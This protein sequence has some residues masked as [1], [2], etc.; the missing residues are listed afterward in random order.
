MMETS[1]QVARQLDEDWLNHLLAQLAEF[2]KL[3]DGG[4]DR[5]ALSEVELDARPG[6]LISLVNS[7]VKYTV[8]PPLIYF[9]VVRDD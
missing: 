8:T 4:V 9:S 3:A 2:G 1:L 5:Q 6:L 7:V